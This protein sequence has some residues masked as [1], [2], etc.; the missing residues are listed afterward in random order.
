MTSINRA[1]RRFL[2]FSK[3]R[4]GAFSRQQMINGRPEGHVNDDKFLDQ[5]VKVRGGHAQVLLN[6]VHGQHW[7]ST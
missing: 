6:P 3:L 5:H 4:A 7:A 2:G 1:E